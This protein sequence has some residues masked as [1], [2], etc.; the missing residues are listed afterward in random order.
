MFWH[1]QAT[2]FWGTLNKKVHQ[3]SWEQ[4]VKGRVCCGCP[5]TADARKLSKRCD[6]EAK[7]NSAYCKTLETEPSRAHGKK[8]PNGVAT[9]QMLL[10]ALMATGEY[11]AEHGRVALKDFQSTLPLVVTLNSGRGRS[12][13][14]RRTAFLHHK[15]GCN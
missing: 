7:S 4:E 13:E 15:C 9:Q 3:D 11:A 6:A 10:K 5:V 12:H 1:S 8:G 14:T 2:T